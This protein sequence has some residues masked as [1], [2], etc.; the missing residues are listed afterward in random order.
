MGDVP[1]AVG[2]GFL[3]NPRFQPT[4]LLLKGKYYK[5][6]KNGLALIHDI[7]II[8]GKERIFFFQS[9]KAE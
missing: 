2:S 6:M 7:A 4:L 1:E 9:E 5:V 8:S 3:N